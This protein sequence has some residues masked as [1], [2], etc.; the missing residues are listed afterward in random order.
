MNIDEI[1]AKINTPALEAYFLQFGKE[2]YLSAEEI[3][4][5]VDAIK[6]LQ[7]NPGGGGT[8]GKYSFSFIVALPNGDTLGKYSN[9]ETVIVEEKTIPEIFEQIG[10][11]VLNPELIAPA[12]TIALSSYTMQEVGSTFT[13]LMTAA[14]NRGQIKGKLV[15]GVWN[16]NDFQNYRSGTA[17]TYTLD[18]N[19][20][21]GNTKSVSRV[22]ELGNNTFTGS[23]NF[24]TGPQPV[25]SA[26][27]N[28][29]SPYAPG[30]LS[31]SKNVPA[32]YMQFHGYRATTPTTSA[33]VRAL[34]SNNFDTVNVFTAFFA[35]NRY[36]IAIPSF[37]TLVKAVTQNNE[38]LFLT[39]SLVTVS[40]GGSG[41]LEYKVYTFQSAVALN[42]NVTITLTS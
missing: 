27:G 39:M 7:N 35:N 29:D 9:G 22:L 10:R 25:N 13:A 6:E 20:Q 16:G 31:D 30:T 2:F 14:L 34:A 11:K 26:G 32:R 28:Y 24:L 23:V 4:A 36:E 12:F 17:S 42:L 21:A 40:D 33:Q 1:V 19:L 3:N 41:T 15:S 38:T 8:N 5:I 18:G 37:K